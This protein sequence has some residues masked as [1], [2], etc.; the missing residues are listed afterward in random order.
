MGSILNYNEGEIKGF[1][2]SG[3]SNINRENSKGFLLSGVS[4][5]CMDSASG[6]FVSGVVN[7]SEKKSEGFF[8]SGVSNVCMDSTSGLFISGVLNY[9]DQNSKGF[10]LSTIN[11][12]SSDVKGFQLGVF[13]Y[14]QKIN[15]VQFG[16]IN[17]L[18]DGEEG[19]PI[20]IISIV[21]NG[22]FEFE[23]TAGEVI[24]SNFNYKMGIEKFYTIFKTGYSSYKNNSVY[25]LGIGF[26]GNIPLSEKQKLSLDLSSNNIYYN[27]KW[28][29]DL[30]L[31]N[32]VDLNYKYQFT[33]KLSFLIGPSFNIYITKEKV[34]G[35]YGTLDIPYTIHTNEWTDGKLYTWIGFNAGLSLSL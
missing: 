8:L 19:L 1:Q 16:V 24:Y 15:G 11:I 29:G 28:D 13:N 14:A 7:Y 3:I 27:N 26:G 33:E 6:L 18:N 5:I 17:Y 22:H 21:K 23:P 32:K 35:R 25:S 31:L 4:N 30:N 2:L 34:D 10:Q 9:S 12:T 20:G